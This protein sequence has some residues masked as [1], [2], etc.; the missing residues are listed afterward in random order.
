MKPQRVSRFE[1]S[2]HRAYTF[3]GG[4]QIIPRDEQPP[5]FTV[6]FMKSF[7]TQE[8]ESQKQEAGTCLKGVPGLDGRGPSP[9]GRV[10]G[11][12]ENKFLPPAPRYLSR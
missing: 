3:I 6:T 2:P 4:V 7:F 9:H 8:H 1:T 12:P 10:H 5:S 11:V